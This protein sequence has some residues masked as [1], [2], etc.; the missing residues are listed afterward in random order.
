MSIVDHREGRKRTEH[1]P[2]RTLPIGLIDPNIVVEV[3]RKD[4]VRTSFVDRPTTFVTSTTFV[5]GD[6][7]SPAA[8]ITRA[9]LIA[10]PA[11]GVAD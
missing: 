5:V 2:A 7:R 4:A 3:V 8:I 11:A 6:D 9:H 1:V 10:Q